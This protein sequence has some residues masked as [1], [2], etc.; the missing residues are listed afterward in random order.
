M[1]WEEKLW[2]SCGSPATTLERSLRRLEDDSRGA[3]RELRRTTRLPGFIILLLLRSHARPRSAGASYENESSSV[4]PV[5]VRGLRTLMFEAELYSAP[6]NKTSDSQRG[7]TMPSASRLHSDAE[8]FH[9]DALSLF[10]D[11]PE[12]PDVVVQPVK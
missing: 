4:R 10:W 6:S 7:N 1:T 8:K 12:L 2:D 5:S 3:V 9:R 11:R